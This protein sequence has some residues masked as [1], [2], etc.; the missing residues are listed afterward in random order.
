MIPLLL[1]VALVASQATISSA[2]VVPGPIPL[3]QTAPASP[4]GPQPGRTQ[5]G[6][7]QPGSGQPTFFPVLPLGADPLQRG[8]EGSDACCQGLPAASGSSQPGGEDT[9][10]IQADR[11]EVDLDGEII[12][13]KGSVKAMYQDYS[14]LAGDLWYDGEHDRGLA[15]GGITLQIRGYQ[16]ESDRLEFDIRNEQAL[17]GPWN[18]QVAGR[19]RFG[20]EFMFLSPAYAYASKATYSPCVA[21]DPGYFLSSNKFEWFPFDGKQHFEGKDVTVHVS[22]APLATLPTFSAS[23]NPR[24]E[25]RER[26]RGGRAVDTKMG[27]NAY[28]GA[29]AAGTGKF[30]LV[31]GHTG[32]LPVR[33]TQGRGLSVGTTQSFTW[34]Q[35]TLNGDAN[36]QTHFRGGSS[37][38]RANLGASTTLP[39]GPNL[40]LGMGYR[41][42][43]AGIAVHRLPEASVGY[44]TVPLGALSLTASSRFGFLL[45]NLVTKQAQDDNPF[46]M[47]TEKI[48]TRAF[49]V[50]HRAVLS[51]AAWKP[52]GFWESQVYL[53]GSVA[54]YLL[55]DA[56]G[57][58]SRQGEH[59]A[60]GSLGLRNTQ[61]WNQVLSTQIGFEAN[62]THGASPFVHDRVFGNDLI[63]AGATI[64]LTPRWATSLGT[65]Y[66]RDPGGALGFKQ[67]DVSLR[68]A[69]NAPCL[70]WAVSLQV[71]SW[72]PFTPALSFDYNFGTP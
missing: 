28:D 65:L 42:D 31:E 3:G 30:K 52:N 4:G 7:T 64:Q 10:D 55:V 54:N 37:G 35:V 17:A 32:T 34:N 38:P 69:Y 27:Y 40:S 6:P 29:F 47:D 66:Y 51:P 15:S 18:G 53:G 22:G 14:L 21:D 46:S 71:Q 16:L 61:W 45:E 5:T 68:L 13:A 9:L 56:K 23:I 48:M 63:S 19:G 41:T 25:E 50:G 49:T 26:Q 39:R 1:G 58:M 11:I 36:Y 2:P 33:L 24:E 43:I 20:G 44:P 8:S 57:E 12:R 62:R 67:S 72:A 60:V 59:Q 70:S